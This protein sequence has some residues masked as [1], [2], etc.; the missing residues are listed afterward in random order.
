MSAVAYCNPLVPVEWIAAHGLQPRWLRLQARGGG[1]WSVT[2]GICPYAGALIDGAA[3][4]DADAL[5]LTTTCDQMRYA[6]ALIER[7]GC[8][9]VFSDERPL[10]VANGRGPAA[11]PRRAQTPEPILAATRRRIAAGAELARVMRAYDAARS[12]MQAAAATCSARQIA[13]ALAELRGPLAAVGTREAITRA[14]PCTPHAPRE[15]SVTRSAGRVLM[16][17]FRWRL[18]ADR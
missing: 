11:L 13:E 9:P 12:A 18:S 16:P 15:E 8:C 17:A 4:I 5:V 1:P 3:G 2:R 14:F 7:R 6:A 10:H